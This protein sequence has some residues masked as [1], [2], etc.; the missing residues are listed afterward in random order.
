MRPAAARKARLPN[1]PHGNSSHPFLV[2]LKYHPDVKAVRP[3]LTREEADAKASICHEM[4]SM[5]P[6]WRD[7]L[8]A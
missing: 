6:S 8:S 2:P 4:K 5:P 1:V 7:I 3:L